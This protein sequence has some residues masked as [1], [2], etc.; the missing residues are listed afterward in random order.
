ML[1]PKYDYRLTATETD[2]SAV[3]RESGAEDYFGTQSRR[4]NQSGRGRFRTVV[5]N[6]RDVTVAVAENTQQ[7][8]FGIGAESEG[9]R[10]EVGFDLGGGQPGQFPGSDVA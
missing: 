1:F 6:D 4:S 8:A 3:G 7:Q 5:G 10:F 9:L 2:A